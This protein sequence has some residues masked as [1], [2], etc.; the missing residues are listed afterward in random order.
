M[1][2]ALHHAAS[3]CMLSRP[4]HFEI[5]NGA[6]FSSPLPTPAR[7]VSFGT[8]LSPSAHHSVTTVYFARLRNCHASFNIGA[9]KVLQCTWYACESIASPIQWRCLTRCYNWALL[10]HL[11]P[12]TSHEQEGTK[13]SCCG[14]SHRFPVPTAQRFKCAHTRAPLC[15]RIL[16]SILLWSCCI[17][18]WNTRMQQLL[19]TFISSRLLCCSERVR[20]AMSSLRRASF[21]GNVKLAVQ[22]T[23][24]TGRSLGR[25]INSTEQKRNKRDRSSS[26]FRRKASNESCISQCP[27]NPYRSLKIQICFHPIRRSWARFALNKGKALQ[28]AYSE[29][30]KDHCSIEAMLALAAGKVGRW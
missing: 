6:Q 28:P 20:G 22:Y 4:I 1:W 13:A 7:L 18:L 23:W 25:V 10:C 8:D 30:R 5:P 14:T 29:L 2:H 16:C 3:V 15:I 11:L 26:S 9:Q 17:S 12:S 21:H 19:L 27:D 24:A